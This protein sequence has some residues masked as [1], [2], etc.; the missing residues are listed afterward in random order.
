MSGNKNEKKKMSAGKKAALIVVLVLLFAGCAVFGV[1]AS[2]LDLFELRFSEETTTDAALKP[3]G[4]IEPTE[5]NSEDESYAFE[6]MSE[7][8]DVYDLSSLIKGWAL[9]GGQIMKK[10]SVINVLVIGADNREHWEEGYGNTDS[11][12][13][14]SL[15]KKN[16]K[17]TISSFYRDCYTYIDLNGGYYGKLNAAYPNGGSKALIKTLQDDFKIA[18]D[19]Y[20]IV[21][22]QTFVEVVDIVG[23]VEVE[24]KRYEANYMTANYGFD[25]PVGE[26]VTLNGEQALAYCRIRK[27]DADG[28]ISRG[29]RQRAFIQSLISKASDLTLDNVGD[30][31]R[32]LTKH[33]KTDCPMSV[34]ISYATQALAGKWYAYPVTQID[35]P[36]EEA[37][38]DYSG[39]SW[40]W[41]VDYPLAA[42]QLQQT[43][44][45]ETNIVLDEDRT[46]AI[47]L[48]WSRGSSRYDYD[49]D[50]DGGYYYYDDEDEPDEPG[51]QDAPVDTDEPVYSD[52]PD[53]PG[54]EI[55]PIEPDEPIEPAEPDDPDEP[56]AGDVAEDEDE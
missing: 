52:D 36:S 8:R 13:V 28:D 35:V 44:Y 45:G 23:G 19:Y 18:I 16:K 20:A 55:E 54:G 39:S 7:V 27:L 11:M 46:T 4:F 25:V 5:P 30:I 10:K 3:T 12:I 42:Q 38:M 34:M 37:R 47:D 29:R 6:Q 40:V 15:D 48:M 26:S 43:I 1:I 22:F 17:I 14:V 49:D 53:E 9:N 21:D 24:V 41:I 2:K 56:P 50:D 32:S 31:I 33:V 51:D